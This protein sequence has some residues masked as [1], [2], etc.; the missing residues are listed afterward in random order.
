MRKV[1]YKMMVSVD[2]F[3]ATPDRSL[4]WH[5]VGDELLGWFVEEMRDTGVLLYG[6]R[7]WDLMAGFW[8]TADARP[9]SP[10][11]ES[12]LAR[13]W[14]RQPKIVFSRVLDRAD[15][16][17]RVIRDDLVG[18]VSKLR[19]QPG[20]D[21]VLS[22]ADVA[23]TFIRHDLVDEYLVYVNPVVLGAGRPMFAEPAR[24]GLT[25]A[26]TRTF[27]GGVVLLRYTRATAPG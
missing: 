5:V 27:G 18:E 11:L 2:G 16:N 12:E 10:P 1:V 21:L 23:R 14:K 15:W 25:L 8:P 7:T 26:E 9:A 24:V 13:L 22:G 3:M 17:T 4:D 20:G 19:E 6:R